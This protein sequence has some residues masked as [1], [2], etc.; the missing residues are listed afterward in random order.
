MA[1]V[2]LATGHSCVR[3]VDSYPLSEL[4]SIENHG[5]PYKA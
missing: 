3:R 2:S 1:F 5:Q 4:V